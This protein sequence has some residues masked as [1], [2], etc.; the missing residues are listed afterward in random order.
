M[1]VYQAILLH[2]IFSL[3]SKGSTGITLGL[4]LKVSLPTADTD[5]LASVIQGCRVLNLF[6]Y[7]T[8]LAKVEPANVLPYI[9]VT[10]EEVKRF[11]VALYRTCNLLSSGARPDSTESNNAMD[12]GWKLT[13]SELRFPPPTNEALWHKVS[14]ND[15]LASATADLERIRSGEIMEPEWISNSAGLLEIVGI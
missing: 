12:A 10:I 11:G 7:P 6:H 13:A 5:L 3:L 1:P 8:I 9:W 2:V 15:W 14:K 4:D